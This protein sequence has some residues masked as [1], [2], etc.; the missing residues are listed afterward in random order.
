MIFFGVEDNENEDTNLSNESPEKE[1][2]SIND[3]NAYNNYKDKNEIIITLK[4]EKND[5]GKKIYFLDNTNYTD[6]KTKEKQYHDN[7]QELMK[8]M[9]NYILMK[10][11]I[12]ILNI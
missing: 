9:L 1:Q 12:N 6:E 5:I 8:K 7:L 10:K 3:I 2:N 11:N 4:I